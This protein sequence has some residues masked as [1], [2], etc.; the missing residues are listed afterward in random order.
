[1]ERWVLDVIHAPR[2]TSVLAASLLNECLKHEALEMHDQ[3][4][5]L[6]CP[7]SASSSIFM[8]SSPFNITLTF[9][10]TTAAASSSLGIQP[11]PTQDYNRL[12]SCH[13]CN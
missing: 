3:P 4:G 10:E 12:H 5:F 6:R 11:L 7:H 13:F 8:L 1:M 9:V 2:E